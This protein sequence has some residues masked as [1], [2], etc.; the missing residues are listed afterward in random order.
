MKTIYNNRITMMQILTQWALSA[1][2]INTT[3]KV[4]VFKKGISDVKEIIDTIGNLSQTLSIKGITSD[5]NKIKMQLCKTLL[6]ITS[7]VNSFATT[8][9]NFT[10]KQ[11]IKKPLSILFKMSGQKLLNE[12]RAIYELI[13]PLIPELEENGF[14][15]NAQSMET[16]NEHISQFDK[17]LVAPRSAIK[18]K[19][20]NSQH[21]VALVKKAFDICHNVLDLNSVSFQS[22]DASYLQQYNI[23]RHVDYT[24]SHH[25]NLEVACTFRDSQSSVYGVIIKV[26]DTEIEGA[27]DLLGF[28]K[29]QR[30]KAGIH[31]V[32]A[33][34]KNKT[35]TSQP[36]QF[37]PRKTVKLSFSFDE[38]FTLPPLLLK[39]ELK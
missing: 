22:I 6:S 4:P 18:N 3:E 20:S 33:T 25:N 13:L 35:I 24:V 28:C 39:E 34:Y 31:T 21:I 12:S 16:L 2:Q 30:I 17:V 11:K 14:A 32:S 7:P 36:I 19:K 10:L 1:Q 8:T 37:S 27:S 29:L 23:Y 15:V 9:E 38:E 5:K 26:N